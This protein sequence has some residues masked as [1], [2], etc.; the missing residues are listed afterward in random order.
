VGDLPE[1]SETSGA[2]EFSSLG[3]SCAATIDG[4]YSKNKRPDNC[5]GLDCTT[6]VSRLGSVAQGRSQ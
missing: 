4:A 2:T 6:G 3:T 1:Q 5:S